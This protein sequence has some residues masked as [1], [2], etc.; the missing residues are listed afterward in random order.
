VLSCNLVKK[1]ISPKE[2]FRMGFE[3]GLAWVYCDLIT[4]ELNPDYPNPFE[5]KYNKIHTIKNGPGLTIAMKTDFPIFDFLGVDV[6]LFGVINKDKSL[7]GLDACI[8]F[9]RVKKKK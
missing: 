9:G 4:L 6:A 7:A 5:Y 8:D 3:A 2:S 1:F